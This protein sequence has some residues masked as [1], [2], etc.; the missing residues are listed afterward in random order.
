MGEVLN[1]VLFAQGKVDLRIMKQTP[2][3]ARRPWHDLS[4][5]RP[6]IGFLM[7]KVQAR[8]LPQGMKELPFGEKTT[9]QKQP[10]MRHRSPMKNKAPNQK[11]E[12][13]DNER[14]VQRQTEKPFTRRQGLG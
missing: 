6:F 13:S 8:R 12:I 11:A 5:I 9:Q 14:D 3:A 1:Q 7:T 10:G 2:G 4:P